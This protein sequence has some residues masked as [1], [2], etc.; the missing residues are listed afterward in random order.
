[1]AQHA[2]GHIK[3]RQGAEV[4]DQFQFKAIGKHGCCHDKG[5][6]ELAALGHIEGDLAASERLSN[7]PQGQETLLFDILDVGAQ[8]SQSVY[9]G[10]HGT[11]AHALRPGEKPLA[12]VA[13]QV[14]RQKTGCRAAVGNIDGLQSA[15][16][17]IDFVECKAFPAQGCGEA[18]IYGGQ[19]L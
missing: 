13:G 19:T 3:V 9:K 11:M 18:G 6:G 15:L 2:E 5:R 10:C 4:A 16:Y 17:V 1:M 12:F 8:G 7:D 14:G